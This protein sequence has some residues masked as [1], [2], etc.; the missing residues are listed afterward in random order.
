M[1]ARTSEI[2]PHPVAASRVHALEY[3]PNGV[4]VHVR[5]L[6]STDHPWQLPNEELAI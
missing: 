6:V 1:V 4:L 3:T 5:L 2:H